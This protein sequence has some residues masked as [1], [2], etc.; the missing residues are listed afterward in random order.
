MLWVD[1]W[2]RKLGLL[3][4]PLIP[5]IPMCRIQSCII[6]DL[7]STTAT[8]L[9]TSALPSSCII[10]PASSPSA[11]AFFLADR[12]RAQRHTP[13]TLWPPPYSVRA[14]RRDLSHLHII[15]DMGGDYS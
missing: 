10:S 2:D 11:I 6:S 7:L 1:G 8:T 13:M 15:V 4:P 9:E 5:L 14:P 3:L 12:G